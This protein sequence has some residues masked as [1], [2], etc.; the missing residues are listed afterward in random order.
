MPRAI[1]A[2]G[3]R[4]HIYNR[5]H[6]KQTLYFDKKDYARMLFYL[7]YCQ[8]TIP[9][10]NVSQAVSSF[11]RKDHFSVSEKTVQ[12]IYAHRV[13]RLECFSLMPNHFHLAVLELQEGGISAYLQKIGIAYTKY[14]NTRYKRSGYLFQGPFQSVAIEDNEQLL[15][16]SAYIHR[17]P[18]ELKEWRT[19]EHLYPWS[20]Y[21]DY[22]D[23]NRWPELLN[24]KIISK[25][26]SNP[27]EYAH[28][29]KTSSTKERNIDIEY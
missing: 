25:Q 17:N 21:Q 22:V 29:V 5:G 2:P 3:E 19:R 18:K 23:I 12:K 11:S 20:S 6:N 24:I 9:T 4:Y 26:F 16:L 10:F 1:I 28:F 8:S 27:N 15:H 7:L 13:V 14:F